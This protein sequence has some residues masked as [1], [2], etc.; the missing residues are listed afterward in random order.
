[1]KG[2]FID[3]KM[4]GILLIFLFLGVTLV[5]TLIVAT[6]TLSGLRGYSTM[7]TYWTESRKDGTYELLRY[8]ETGNKEHLD[9]FDESLEI[10][11]EARDIRNELTSESPDY[12]LVREKLLLIHTQPRDIKTMINIFEQLHSVEH[13]S[14]A[15]QLWDEANQVIEELENIALQ[16][17]QM[18]TPDE[19][20][21]E[22]YRN[23][24]WE[25]DED[26]RSQKDVIAE[27]LSEGTALITNI[28]IYMGVALGGILLIFGSLLSYRFLKSIKHW[29]KRID[30]SEQRYKSLFEQNPNIVFSLDDSG[31]ITSGNDAFFQLSGYSREDI[32]VKDLTSFPVAG[33]IEDVQKHFDEALSGNPQNFEVRWNSTSGEVITLYSTMLPIRIDGKIEGVFVISEDISY[34]K[35]A[36]EKI[37]SQLEEKNSLLSEVHDRV[38][39]NLAL[40][41]SMLQLQE[42]YLKDEFAKTYMESTISRIHSLAMVHERLYQNENFSSVRL[43]E[44]IKELVASKKNLFVEE[45]KHLD[46]ILTLSP[47]K[48]DIKQAVPC[49]LLLNELILNA[50]KFA[51]K[52]RSKGKLTV[53]LTEQDNFVTIKVKDNG[54]GLPKGFDLDN[55]STLGMT[56]IRTLSKQLKANLNI[57]SNGGSEFSF[58]F[59]SV[60]GILKS[61]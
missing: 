50:F 21:A 24:I 8:L 56:L 10:I 4:I 7:Q 9:N 27:S 55:Q 33:N 23:Q 39:N 13:L 51:F 29:G 40:I 6:N 57:H 37:K 61:A 25:L 35:F 45:G 32:E 53:E 2:L 58:K 31:K 5:S 44:F 22:I 11:R 38:K 18:P 14:N 1:M 3:R 12:E 26:L 47:V 34:Q 43:D 60:N 46:V 19:A 30:I 17:H 52:G 54:I 48:L 59:N 28:I 49:G 15:V 16:L 41:S 42:A 20:E 36:E